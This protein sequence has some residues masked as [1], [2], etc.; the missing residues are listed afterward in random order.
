MQTFWSNTG[1]TP[2]RAAAGGAALTDVMPDGRRW[3]QLFAPQLCRAGSV[4][5]LILDHI[6]S[7]MAGLSYVYL[8]YW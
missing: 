4:N 5:L 7:E 2:C 6:S 3:L 8:G 1:R